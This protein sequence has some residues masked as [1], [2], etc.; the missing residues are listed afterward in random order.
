MLKRKL[1]AVVGELKSFTGKESLFIITA[2]LCGFLINLD[3]SIIRPVSISLLISNFGSE[4]VT[5]AWLATVPLNFLVV[6]LYNRYLPKIGHF[7]M[8]LATCANI[9]LVHASTYLFLSKIP[10]LAFF[11]YVWKD[12]YVLMLFQQLWS[13]IHSTVK[14][15]RAKYLYGIIFAVGALG[16]LCGSTVPGFLAVKMGS[17]SLLLAALPVCFVIIPMFRMMLKASGFL[18]KT[19]ENS[20]EA[21]KYDTSFRNNINLIFKSKALLFILIAVLFM[22]L[23]SAVIDFQFSVSLEHAVLTEDLRTQYCGRVFSIVQMSTLCLQVVG[24]FLL[25]HLFGLRNS[26]FFVPCVLGLN[27]LGFML[28]PTFP[29]ITYCFIAVKAFDFSLFGVI[30]EMMYLPMSLEEKF[31]AKAVI[32]VFVHRTSKA[33]AG[34]M[35]LFLQFYNHGMNLQLLTISLIIIFFGWNLAVYKLC[36][37]PQFQQLEEA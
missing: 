33:I 22:Q 18:D 1:Q 24:T 29:V 5:Y 26:H 27:A 2:M 25:V 12:I 30:K 10:F 14:K 28:F 19:S 20:L 7:K 6:A 23:S 21:T 32:D 17:K 13:V 16:S 3:Y 36:P 11:L 15:G 9:A 8:I 37:K 35:I 34:F 4:S 31:R